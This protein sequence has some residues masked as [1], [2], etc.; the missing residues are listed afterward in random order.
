MSHH[1][2][3]TNEHLIGF[4]GPTEI[5][6]VVD[7]RNDETRIL[8]AF[9]EYRKEIWYCTL[10]DK[11]TVANQLAD[12]LAHLDATLDGY[13]VGDK[14]KTDVGTCAK[15]CADIGVPDSDKLLDMVAS[16]RRHCMLMYGSLES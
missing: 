16:A 9:N 7:F 15:L 3:P 2:Q 13:G 5:Q 6:Y 14:M 4:H 1:T 10:V 11:A 8:K 12:K